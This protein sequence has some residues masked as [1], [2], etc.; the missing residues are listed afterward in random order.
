M[1]GSIPGRRGVL[2]PG[3]EG[4]EAATSGVVPLADHLGS[5][6]LTGLLGECARVEK[7][8]KYWKV[9]MKLFNSL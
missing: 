1:C 7:E 6:L 2:A 8:N 5:L 4:R 9:T 3:T